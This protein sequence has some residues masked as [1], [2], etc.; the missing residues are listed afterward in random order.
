MSQLNELLFSIAQSRRAV[1]A[2]NGLMVL[3]LALTVVQW[4]RFY[5]GERHQ[6]APGRP[7]KTMVAAPAVGFNINQL[8]ANQ[9][10]GTPSTATLPQNIPISS[11][12]LKLTGII[13]S[14]R[15]GLA[16]ISV[17]R[18]P[19][20]PFFVGEIVVE[21]AVLDAVLPDR[22]ILSRGGAKESIL[23][24]PDQLPDH[25]SATNPTRPPESRS[26]L[27]KIQKRSRERQVVSREAVVQAVSDPEFLKQALI[28]PNP[29]GGFVVKNISAGSV[30]EKI[31]LRID[32]VIRQV[33]DTPVNSMV[34]VMQ[35]Y[36]LTSGADKASDI[37]VVIERQGKE[38][39]LRFQ[40]N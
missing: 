25:P 17:N 31:G 32:D 36:R 13:A 27:N 2:I 6:F 33:N 30:F 34:D 26:L 12:N 19:Q 7:M 5:M 16:L 11:L 24:D 3:L 14:D 22:I 21:G 9:I 15:G 38:E 18:Q 8:I 39:T 40:L 35:L 37:N 1:Q 28:V 23:L 29:A 10:F 20:A 4:T